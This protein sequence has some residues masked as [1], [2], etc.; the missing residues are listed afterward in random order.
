MTMWIF[1][2]LVGL[3]S[4]GAMSESLAWESHPPS[5]AVNTDCQPT[6][7]SAD[8]HR[9]TH[10]A[11]ADGTLSSSNTHIIPN[12]GTSHISPFVSISLSVLVDCHVCATFPGQIFLTLNKLIVFN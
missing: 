9:A 2:G 11:I 10:S 6:C 7:P 5:S 8:D 12:P 1:R 3:S 4:K